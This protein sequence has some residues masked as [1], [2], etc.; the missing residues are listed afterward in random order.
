MCSLSELRNH[1]LTKALVPPVEFVI[2]SSTEINGN[3]NEPVN[4]SS[5]GPIQKMKVRNIAK[6]AL[7]LIRAVRIIE[8]GITV[9]AFSISSAKIRNI[10]EPISHGPSKMGEILT[11]M[12]RPINRIKSVHNRHRTH[13]NRLRITR[14]PPTINKSPKHNT[15]RCFHRRQVQEY[16]QESKEAQ[17]MKYQDKRFEAR[18]N[19][20]QY[21]RE[22][23]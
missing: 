9:A 22:K 1:G 12:S 11:H 16:E 8:Y 20:A 7:P 13:Q 21:R 18:E 6:P 19:A 4:T 5:S 14:K 23:D 17:N 15:G 2:L 10:R 3:E